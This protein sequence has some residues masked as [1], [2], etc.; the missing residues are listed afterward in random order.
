SAEIGIGAAVVLDGQLLRGTHGFA[1]ELGH[2]PVRPEGPECACGG[3]GCLEQ[4][5]GEEAVL[6]ASGLS[7]EEAAAEHPG[8]GGRIA[9]LAVRAAI[10]DQPTRRA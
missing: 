4:Y 6:R 7:P 3:R 2:V 9:V 8:P 5:A 1:G 10:G